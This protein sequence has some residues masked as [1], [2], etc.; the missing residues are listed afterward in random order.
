MFRKHW[1]IEVS[2]TEKKWQTLSNG[3]PEIP[4]SLQTLYFKTLWGYSV[5]KVCKNM[6]V[7]NS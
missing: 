7:R 3:V 5:T 6:Y 2:S 4:V 1:E